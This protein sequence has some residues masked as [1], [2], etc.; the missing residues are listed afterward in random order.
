MTLLIYLDLEDIK[1]HEIKIL[2]YLFYKLPYVLLNN[3]KENASIYFSNSNKFFKDIEVKNIY[4]YLMRNSF[5]NEKTINDLYSSDY[6]NLIFINNKKKYFDNILNIS[7]NIIILNLK[8]PSMQILDNIILKF[9]ELSFSNIDYLEKYS[10]EKKD[11]SLEVN[12]ENY[13]F[14]DFIL[15]EKVKQHYNK[16]L[17]EYLSKDSQLSIDKITKK[18]IIKNKNNEIEKNIN[19]NLE[20]LDDISNSA[21]FFISTISM[22]DYLSEMEDNS[23]M[24]IMININKEVTKLIFIPNLVETNFV[25]DIISYNDFLDLRKSKIEELQNIYISKIKNN[26][27]NLTNLDRNNQN[28]NGLIPLYINSNHFKVIYKNLEKYIGIVFTGQELG[29]DKRFIRIFY[30]ILADYVYYICNIKKENKLNDRE[31][32]LFLN[33]FRFCCEISKYMGYHKGIKKY[34][35]SLDEE[36]KTNLGAMEFLISQI[37]TIG[38]IE[39]LNDVILIYKKLENSTTNFDITITIL[40]NVI[41]YF[42]SWTKFLNSFES[43]YGFFDDISF[44]K[45][46]DI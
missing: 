1:I 28:I 33:Y 3:K 23:F 45:N 42:G 7:K 6:T 25:S 20:D 24:G 31:I 22:A 32:I 40:E 2:K 37:F 36:Y 16:Y 12:Y 27:I 29:Y 26:E 17:S 46:I 34:V 43:N 18:N 10:F 19:I 14:K 38:N 9:N 21:E 5:I 44:I 39:L 11:F 41:K 8:T 4:Y 15:N 13:P 30:K 35:E